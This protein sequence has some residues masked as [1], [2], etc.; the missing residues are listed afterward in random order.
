MME[1]SQEW[2]RLLESNDVASGSSSRVTLHDRGNMS[3]DV[4]HFT[5][6]TG[7]HKH[8]N[9]ESEMRSVQKLRHIWQEAREV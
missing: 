7:N 8:G 2:K 4:G 6:D 1:R 9:L 3:A 5:N